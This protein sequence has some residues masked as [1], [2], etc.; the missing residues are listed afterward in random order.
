MTQCSAIK[1]DP[2]GGSTPS[3]QVDDGGL[4][5]SRYR[6]IDRYLADGITAIQDVGGLAR[7]SV[8]HWYGRPL[9]RVL[10][11]VAARR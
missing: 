2:G 9:L 1:V 8:V 10:R 6:M 4:D 11:V 5:D 3:D 7:S